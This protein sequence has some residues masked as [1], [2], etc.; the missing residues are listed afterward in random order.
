MG[1]FIDYISDGENIFLT[2]AALSLALAFLMVAMR[3]MRILL[4]I[5]GLFAI[6][7]YTLQ[8]SD[9]V[10]LIWVIFLTLA[11][12][13]P[14]ALLLARSRRGLIR[15]EE[16]ELLEEV[17]EVEDPAHQRRL[18]DLVEWRDI[19]AG[20]TLVRQGQPRPPLIYIATGEASVEF[21]G[22]EVGV[23]GPGDF[24]GEMSLVSGATASASV[25]TRTVMRVARIER[26]GIIRLS[27]AI[28][29]LGSAFDRALNLGMAAKIARMN[30]AAAKDR[31]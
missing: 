25:I 22:A 6:V 20:E 13:I 4:L 30:E 21:D 15:P 28:P 18:L 10:A 12:A 16:R 5:A 8:Q 27:G 11:N 29:E 3:D 26:D 2:M 23:A 1:A 24:L 19:G 31:E 17:L 7:H 9:S 14:L